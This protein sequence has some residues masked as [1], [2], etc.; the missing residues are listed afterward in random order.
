MTLAGATLPTA[1]SHVAFVCGEWACDLDRVIL[2]ADSRGEILPLWRAW[3]TTVPVLE[4]AV[5]SGRKPPESV[6]QRLSDEFRYR[7]SLTAAEE[8]EEWLGQRG[9][10]PADL[11]EHFVRTYWAS[12]AAADQPKELVSPS[13]AWRERLAWF[14]AD[15]LLSEHFDGI[16]RQLAWRVAASEAASE[17]VRRH[18]WRT[19]K[20]SRGD[21]WDTGHS[22]SLT[23][24]ANPEAGTVFKPDPM[25][26]EQLQVLEAAY[27]TQRATVLTGANRERML[28]HGRHERP[29][30]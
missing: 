4:R 24:A 26:A 9:L 14:R 12:A 1:K 21:E 25:W 18:T 5:A 3:R 13:E 20:R 2:A 28:H 19:T 22:V 29:H 16:A 23:W 27:E 7:R 8:C 10:T 15:L 11:R 30:A 17:S 6:L